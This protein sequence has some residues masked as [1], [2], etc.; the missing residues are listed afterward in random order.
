MYLIIL[1]NWA[2]NPLYLINLANEIIYNTLY[3]YHIIP[4]V[5]ILKIKEKLKIFL[6]KLDINQKMILFEELIVYSIIV[7]YGYAIY[8]VE[9]GQ[10]FVILNAD[11]DFVLTY[12]KVF[13]NL[14]YNI[15]FLENTI[16]DKKKIKNKIKNIL[17][18]GNFSNNKINI[19]DDINEINVNILTK[20]VD[21]PYFILSFNI[22][23]KDIYIYNEKISYF[24]DYL[25]SKLVR[26][27]YLYRIGNKQILHNTN[28]YMIFVNIQLNISYNDNK[29]K[30]FETILNSI[31]KI[32][33]EYSKENENQTEL[34]KIDK[35]YNTKTIYKSKSLN[36]MVNINELIIKNILE[37][38]PKLL[39]KNIYLHKKVEQDIKNLFISNK[40]L[41]DILNNS[42]FFLDYSFDK[43]EILENNFT[44]EIKTM[45][46][47]FKKTLIRYL[48]RIIE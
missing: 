41:L 9:Y 7:Y 1:K 32:I 3:I 18:T 20:Y 15:I 27:K 14:Y 45:L 37:S 23:F 40:Y 11:K 43:Q 12:N 38:D 13:Y 28:D 26:T 36:K 21:I 47:N 17:K 34:L 29:K 48:S 39:N 30:I 33:K 16:I 2:F 19:N 10:N 24:N 8:L 5:I 31:I 35:F 6:S 4:E 22:Y 25:K 44:N 42:V 46:I